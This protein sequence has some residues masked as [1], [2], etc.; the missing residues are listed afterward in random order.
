MYPEYAYRRRRRGCLISFITLIVAIVLIA[1]L[2]WIFLPKLAVHSVM[3]D[4]A[5]SPVP[6]ETRSELRN[7]VNEAV[8][9][10]GRYGVTRDQALRIVDNISAGEIRGMIGDLLAA[11]AL[12]ADTIVRVISS[13]IDLTGVDLETLK[14]DIAKNLDEAALR[15]F[16]QS[17]ERNS[18]SL[19]VVIPAIK[20]TVK[21]ALL[22]SNP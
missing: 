21:E 18:F 1:V 4:T 2:G 22:Q 19:P 5:L 7:A 17:L 11:P 3:S 12:D 8:G 9:S 6:R 10:L 15:R 16:L 20:E 14:A 13:D